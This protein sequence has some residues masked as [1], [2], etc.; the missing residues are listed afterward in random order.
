M[1]NL[2]VANSRV[3]SAI[4]SRAWIAGTCFGCNGRFWPTICAV[5]GYDAARALVK[6]VTSGTT[7]RVTLAN[8]LRGVSFDGPRGATSIDPAISDIVQPI[9]VYQTVAG[10]G[11]CAGPVRWRRCW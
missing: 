2:K 3:R 8:P 9:Y 5:Q 10:E 7:D 4:S 11:G 6:A 1:A